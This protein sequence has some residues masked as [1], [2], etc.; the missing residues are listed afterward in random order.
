LKVL[1]I[2]LSFVGLVIVASCVLFIYAF[3]HVITHPDE[4]V[5]SSSAPATL[6][7]DPATIS[8]AS[9]KAQDSASQPSDSTLPNPSGSSMSDKRIS[10]DPFTSPK[11]KDVTGAVDVYGIDPK[12]VPSGRQDYYSNMVLDGTASKL[13]FDTIAIGNISRPTT[14]EVP[15]SFIG[16]KPVL[17]SVAI[18]DGTYSPDLV[19]LHRYDFLADCGVTV[20]TEFHNTF[21]RSASGDWEQSAAELKDFGHEV[22]AQACWIA[23]PEVVP[24]RLIT[25]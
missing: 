1:K 24:Q 2:F 14:A 25:P 11:T 9:T 8:D 4:Q 15:K 10:T 20:Q 21:N 6:P 16:S 3:D 17:Y 18:R 5:S 7:V 12:N 23:Y 22:A 19:Y 13:D